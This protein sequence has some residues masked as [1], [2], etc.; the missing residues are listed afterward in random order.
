MKLYSFVDIMSEARDSFQ[1]KE[2]LKYP[3]E[4][5]EII[6]KYPNITTWQ[7]FVYFIVAPTMCFQFVYPRSPRVRKSWLLKRIA[8]FLLSLSLMVILIQQYMMPLLVN[9]LPIINKEEINYTALLERILK[10]SLP[11]LYV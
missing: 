1:S 5:K 2:Y 3:N 4:I 8:E 9:T 7:H 10:L 11:N 6:A